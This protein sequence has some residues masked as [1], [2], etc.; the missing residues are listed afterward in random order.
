[1]NLTVNVS[2]ALLALLLLCLPLSLPSMLV[3]LTGF[4]HV[5]PDKL[6]QE[7]CAIELRMRVS[8]EYAANQTLIDEQYMIGLAKLNALARRAS[9]FA[10]SPVDGTHQ[11]SLT[12]QTVTPVENVCAITPHAIANLLEFL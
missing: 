6:F 10:E 12:P 11:G 7:G 5:L 3:T 9:R 1:M 2:S 4:V 8:C